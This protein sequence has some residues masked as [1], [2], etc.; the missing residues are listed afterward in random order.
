MQITKKVALALPLLTLLSTHAYANQ[1]NANFDD[2]GY[3]TIHA[4]DAVMDQQTLTGQLASL[5][6]TRFV[7]ETQSGIAHHINFDEN[8]PVFKGKDIVNLDVLTDGQ[9]VV[10]ITTGVTNKEQSEAYTEEDDAFHY[11]T[12]HSVQAQAILI[13]DDN[14]Y[15]IYLGTFEKRGSN[16]SASL[17]STTGIITLPIDSEYTVYDLTGGNTGY[18]LQDLSG[19]NF[20]V[21]YSDLTG[22]DFGTPYSAKIILLA[23]NVSEVLTED[24]IG[25][26]LT[27]PVTIAP[28][29]TP[30]P[31]PAPMPAPT[32]VSASNS[33]LDQLP[34]WAGG[35]LTPGMPR[36]IQAS[37][38]HPSPIN[39]HPLNQAN[40][41][42]ANELIEELIEEIIEE[43]IDESY[44]TGLEIIIEDDEIIIE[45]N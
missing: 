40:N 41:V 4:I 24:Q 3:Q 29:P 32:S 27:P 6:H 44:Y 42:Q 38:P 15:N 14:E 12:T 45:F 23:E 19:R 8:T 2:H 1:M 26:L 7:L 39:H 21:I 43:I 5:H 20:L 17:V 16:D 11:T 18:H 9:Q 37:I 36:Q 31:V 35:T 10:V 28:T 33:F 25:H 13:R 30:M 34:T 22:G